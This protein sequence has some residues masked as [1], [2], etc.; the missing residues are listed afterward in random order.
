M[1]RDRLGRT[2]DLR[3]DGLR[4][5]PGGVPLGDRSSRGIRAFDRVS[6]SVYISPL[7]RSPTDIERNL[8]PRCRDRSADL[9]GPA[10]GRHA[11]VRARKMRLSRRHPDHHARSRLVSDGSLLRRASSLAAWRRSSSTRSRGGPI[12]A[13]LAHPCTLEG[14]STHPRRLL[15]SGLGSACPRRA[16]RFSRSSWSAEANRRSGQSRSSA[17]TRESAMRRASA[18]PTAGSVAA[19]MPKLTAPASGR[20]A[21]RASMGPPRGSVTMTAP[22]GPEDLAGA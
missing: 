11:P 10:D 13:R 6:G 20:G 22:T 8:R 1:A 15:S 17:P 19:R 12:E 7:K 18:S 16:R 3:P 14:A 2:P 4:Q 5:D 21:S 9:G